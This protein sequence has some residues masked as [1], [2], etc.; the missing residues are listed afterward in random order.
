M[1]YVMA[2]DFRRP[3]GLS[4]RYEIEVLYEVHESPDVKCKMACSRLFLGRG[5]MAFGGL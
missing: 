3:L 2:A 1:I 5:T 4:K